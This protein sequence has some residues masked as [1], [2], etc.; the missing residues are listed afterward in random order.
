SCMLNGVTDLIM[1]KADVLN[2]FDE[3]L[4]CNNYKIKNILTDET[5]F[6]FNE[7]IEAQYIKMKGWNSEIKLNHIPKELKNYMEL[8]ENETQLPI[9]IMSYGPD[10]EATQIL[11][12]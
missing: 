1:M 6:N 11:K 5:P 7:P 4:V 9:S 3:I 2:D 8:I 10:R 12:P